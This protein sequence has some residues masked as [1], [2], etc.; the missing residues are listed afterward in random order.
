M[1]E[2]EIT[3]KSQIKENMK[4]YN[5][6]TPVLS[7]IKDKLSKQEIDKYL[8][9]YNNENTTFKFF[10]DFDNNKY[11]ISIKLIP[12]NEY[13]NINDLLIHCNN[14]I[15][16]LLFNHIHVMNNF[17]KEEFYIIKPTTKEFE[18]IQIDLDY[19]G[20]FFLRNVYNNNWKSNIDNK[21]VINVQIDY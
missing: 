13:Y 14:N 16:K 9:I 12:I 8:I 19:T 21:L 7:L 5:Y 3:T 18:H 10:T 4:K 17:I 1:V 11:T 2:F 20:T 6:M 15:Q